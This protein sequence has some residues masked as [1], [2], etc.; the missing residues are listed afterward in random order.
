[1]TQDYIFIGHVHD[2]VAQSHKTPQSK[3]AGIAH[4]TL[5][6][7]SGLRWRFNTAQKLLVCSRN[8]SP[9]EYERIESHLAKRGYEV[10]KQSLMAEEWAY[11]ATHFRPKKML[12]AQTLNMNKAENVKLT[13]S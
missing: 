8:P 9:T 13:M 10:V 6:L 7:F 3:T 5:G 12:K 1:M 4:N 2:D 11:K